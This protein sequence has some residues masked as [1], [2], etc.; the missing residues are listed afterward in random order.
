MEEGKIQQEITN[1]RSFDN[2]K[3]VKN[4][5]YRYC[6]KSYFLKQRG[7]K[8]AKTCMNINTRTLKMKNELL[9]DFLSLIS[10]SICKI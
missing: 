1:E 3:V 5:L 9:R 4:L 6:H 2:A 10:E 8:P 7:R